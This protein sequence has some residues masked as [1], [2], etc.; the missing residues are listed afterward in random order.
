LIQTLQE[1]ATTYNMLCVAFMYCRYSE[2]LSTAD[3]LAAV[4][5]QL[6]ETHQRLA[7][8]LQPLYSQLTLEKTRPSRVELLNIL[9]EISKEFRF[10][11]YV[12]DGVDEASKDTQTELLEAFLSLKGNLLITSRPLPFLKL[13]V[14]NA[15]FVDA[16]ASDKDIE[17]LISHKIES[18]YAMRTLIG[19]AGVKEQIIEKIKQT[20]HGM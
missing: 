9:A 14:P 16:R 4:L 18:N 8:L 12:I 3:I 20:A 5:R 1:E 2:P 19:T 15:R 11:A 10:N 17:L 7:P 13:V 6:L